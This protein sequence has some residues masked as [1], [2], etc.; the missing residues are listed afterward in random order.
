VRSRSGDVF[1]GLAAR[2]NDVGR[3]RIG[4]D[5]IP[6]QGEVVTPNYFEVLGVAPAMGRTFGAD[7]NTGAARP[8]RRAARVDP[9]VVLRNS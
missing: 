7:E 2:G 4:L 5:V 6:L 3:L 8:A 9:L 1:S